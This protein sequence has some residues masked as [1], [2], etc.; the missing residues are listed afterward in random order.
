MILTEAAEPLRASQSG[1]RNPEDHL[2]FL[3]LVED[4]VVVLTDMAAGGRYPEAG[5]DS[6]QFHCMVKVLTSVSAGCIQQMECSAAAAAAAVV[7]VV[8][9]D[10]KDRIVRDS[11]P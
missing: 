8:V 11:N 4:I 2:E 1:R 3:D 7:V 6:Q 10:H 9:V 5:A